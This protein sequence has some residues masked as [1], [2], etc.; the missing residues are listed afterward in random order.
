[1]S[2]ETTEEAMAEEQSDAAQQSRLSI[3][4]PAEGD[5]IDEET[6]MLFSQAVAAND[7]LAQLNEEDVSTMVSHLTVTPY[8][9]DEMIVQKGETAT[10]LG[11]VLSGSLQAYVN[12]KA[13]G[14]PMVAGALVGEIAFFAG[15][16]RQ[17]DVKGS[18]S[19]FIA[20]VMMN[21]L[22]QFFQSA[23]QTAHKL[24]RAL[25]CSSV[26]RITKNQ[27][28]HPPLSLE[29]APQDAEDEVQ[30]WVT[31]HFSTVMAKHDVSE[32]DCR[33]L[34]ACMQLHRFAKGDVLV[35]AFN[36]NEHV[37]FVISGEVHVIKP[38]VGQQRTT[39]G[40]HGGMLCDV[41]YFE[42]GRLPC[43]MVGHVAG[44]LGGISRSVIESLVLQKPLLAFAV[45]RMV[46]SSA[47]HTCLKLT[48]PDRESFTHPP[49][50]EGGEAG[51]AVDPSS[52]GAAGKPGEGGS[53]SFEVFYRNKLGRDSIRAKAKAEAEEVKAK[54]AAVTA[55][56]AA[57]K[58]KLKERNF[59]LALKRAQSEKR[60]AEEQLAKSKIEMTELENIVKN[61]KA[62]TRGSFLNKKTRRRGSVMERGDEPQPGSVLALAGTHAASAG[63]SVS[64]ADEAFA[65]RA[66]LEMQATMTEVKE[67]RTLNQMLKEKIAVSEGEQARLGRALEQGGKD[68][69]RSNMTSS[70]VRAALETSF[71]SER[72]RFIE[73][74]AEARRGEAQT[75]EEC[76]G[77]QET[78]ARKD[79]ELLACTALLGAELLHA[80]ASERE[81]RRVIELQRLAAKGLGI[82]YV[83]QLYP[84]KK[85]LVR[86]EH[87]V[88]QD[89]TLLF[90]L[91]WQQK[92]LKAKNQKL[93]DELRQAQ[94]A[95]VPATSQLEVEATAR[96]AAE[97]QLAIA[98]ADVTRASQ[99][100]EQLDARASHLVSQLSK[101][102]VE[103]R[104]LGVKLDQAHKREDAAARELRSQ[105]KHAATAVEEVASMARRVQ[106]IED[107]F[108]PLV[109]TTATRSAAQHR[110]A[111]WSSLHRLG[112]APAGLRPSASTPALW[113][114]A[115]KPQTSRQGLW[116]P[117]V[118]DN[119][120][121]RPRSRGWTPSE[122]SRPTRLESRAQVQMNSPA[123]DKAVLRKDHFPVL[124]PAHFHQ[125]SLQLE[126][127]R[128]GLAT[129]N[130]YPPQE[131]MATVSHDV[132]VDL[133]GTDSRRAT[134]PL[135]GLGVAQRDSKAK[136]IAARSGREEPRP[137][138][139]H[140]IDTGG[141]GH[142]RATPTV[143]AIL[144]PWN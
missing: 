7:I 52:S 118:D 123:R 120:A 45:L 129:P 8:D 122:T 72:A 92:V 60:Q 134:T 87:K 25:G 56:D 65:T 86:L 82:A 76:Q 85:E 132:L 139:T 54:A 27:A 119:Q 84:L 75:R 124:S 71:A 140:S 19:G 5:D 38:T 22:A 79:G 81:L 121:A 70:E 62:K 29:L 13:V 1:M 44:V 100:A 36:V 96:R 89:K 110:T 143:S 137:C 64:D 103:A 37:C 136:A 10:W 83:S 50:Q 4:P 18:S 130:V 99:R 144:S 35:D 105:T 133:Y 63:N 141:Q 142:E 138:S 24:V 127:A 23:P 95:L 68:L 9:V 47:V 90:T 117:T 43:T 67:L 30:T 93:E 111:R 125:A 77:L 3:A 101:A 135:T 109:A 39:V 11:I 46:G 15:G 97:A 49:L 107:S 128:S 53:G 58:F 88:E 106:S 51:G 108:G 78:L 6:E 116:P 115:D 12:E 113:E 16:T 94:Q 73:S 32:D 61:L 66:E 112:T 104:R 40:W 34:V 17:A 131:A 33:H 28:A 98:Q 59:R 48:E 102:E 14:P 31:E 57:A 41:D 42:H 26:S 69:E 126:A 55:D 114:Q 91:P 2:E 74:L 21:E 80:E 20:T